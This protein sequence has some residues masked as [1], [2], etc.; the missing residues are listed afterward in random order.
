MKAMLLSLLRARAPI[1]RCSPC[2]LASRVTSRRA[3]AALAISSVTKT[4]GCIPSSFLSVSLLLAGRHPWNLIMRFF[5]A[6][7]LPPIYICKFPWIRALL[8]RACR[9]QRFKIGAIPHAS[10]MDR[11]QCLP[12][13]V[14]IRTNR[15]TQIT[16][17]QCIVK[18]LSALRDV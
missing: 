11:V 12:P 1:T 18:V 4:M 16:G 13:P 17:Y 6:R 14:Y 2:L 3:Q 8:S 10:H 5:C 7:L 15:F 9:A